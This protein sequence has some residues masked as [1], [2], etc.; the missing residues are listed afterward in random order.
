MIQLHSHSLQF[1][2]PDLDKEIATQIHDYSEKHREAFCASFRDAA[3]KKIEPNRINLR[4]K[5][6]Q[7]AAIERL[8]AS[9]DHEIQEAW[10]TAW[11]EVAD[12]SHSRCSITFQRTLRLPDDGKVYP[13]P[14]GLGAFPLRPVDRCSSTCP[15]HWLEKGGVLLP[16]YQAEA[17]WLLFHAN[18]PHAMKI[19]AGSVNAL[20]GEIDHNG[21]V[22]NPQN[23]LTLPD[24]PW[25]DG[26]KVSPNTVR[27]FVA[28]P[29]GSGFT[30]SEQLA[31]EQTAGGMV[32]EIIHMKPTRLLAQIVKE[33]KGAMLERVM[34]LLLGDDWRAYET[35]ELCCGS[36]M[37]YCSGSMGLGG[38]GKIQ[39]EIYQDEHGIEAWEDQG[40]I[41]LC[42]HI[43]NAMTWRAVTGEN[44]PHPPITP[45]EYQR[46]RIPWF[47]FYRD[48]LTPL[49][50]TEKM[51]GLK[52]VDE[53]AAEKGLTKFTD[54]ELDP[55]YVVQYGNTRRPDEVREWGRSSVR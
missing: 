18:L 3:R 37:E 6:P 35:P 51:A 31:P 9:R 38:G 8:A 20:T 39:Q 21:L 16:M 12:R 24:Q 22:G 50:E 32:I 13:L 25:L 4:L 19:T 44:P 14:A 2:F 33:N 36:V 17:L 48:D 23:Y 46:H 45:E 29:V 54:G 34:D 15:A 40:A 7:C 49:Q 43:C 26:F 41:R 10:M 30:A 27:Q 47:D 55:E 53:V 28:M 1:S 5:Q 42:V 11:S 52:S